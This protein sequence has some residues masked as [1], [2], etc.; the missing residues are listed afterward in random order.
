MYTQ[1]VSFNTSQYQ[2]RSSSAINHNY[3]VNNSIA[4]ETLAANR[5]PPLTGSQFETPSILPFRNITMAKIEQIRQDNNRLAAQRDEDLKCLHLEEEN[6][7]CF[8][9]V[10]RIWTEQKEME[11]NRVKLLIPPNDVNNENEE[12][13][14]VGQKLPDTV[15]AK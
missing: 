1:N 7:R 2:Y 14:N 11:L 13:E 10:I 4:A 12:N 8:E 3:S 5:L 15:V 9:T 6:F